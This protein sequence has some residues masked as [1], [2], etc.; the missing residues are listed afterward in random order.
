MPEPWTR[1]SPFWH[2]FILG[3][4]QAWAIGGTLLA[5]VLLVTWTIPMFI[6]LLF[7]GASIGVAG[8][9]RDYGFRLKP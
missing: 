6:P 4:Y 3:M 8:W 5:V 1:R 9:K 7:I 2:G